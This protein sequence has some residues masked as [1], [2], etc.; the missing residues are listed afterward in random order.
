[1]TDTTQEIPLNDFAHSG[2]P[3]G[4]F[5]IGTVFEVTNSMYK[6]QIGRWVIRSFRDPWAQVSTVCAPVPAYTARRL[7]KD[8]EMS[9]AAGA[10]KNYN[11]EQLRRMISLGSAQIV[12]VGFNK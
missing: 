1:M 9:W 10:S 2:N 11:A 4:L 6:N 3:D 7:R 5:R 8:G 12:S